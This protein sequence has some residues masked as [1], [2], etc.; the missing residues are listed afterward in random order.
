MN[1]QQAYAAFT[2]ANAEI[3]ALRGRVTAFEKESKEIDQIRRRL[4]NTEE[5]ML[6]AFQAFQNG[7]VQAAHKAT[8][9]YKKN[10][11]INTVLAAIQ[12]HSGWIH[13]G[14]LS[15]LLNE[16]GH[17]TSRGHRFHASIVAQNLT[18][19]KKEGQVHNNGY[20]NGMWRYGKGA[21]VFDQIARG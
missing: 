2:T 17:R 6:Q 7:T 13:Y 8:R 12:E 3:E 5:C 18:L 15:K 16:K 4:S 21:R 11:T 19:L 10:S 9:R 1:I 14:E 20:G